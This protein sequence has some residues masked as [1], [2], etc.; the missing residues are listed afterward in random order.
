MPRSITDV[1]DPRETPLEDEI[2][3]PLVEKSEVASKDAEVTNGQDESLVRGPEVNGGPLADQSFS[4]THTKTEPKEIN[5]TPSSVLGTNFLHHSSNKRKDFFG[6]AES[7]GV[8]PPT[9]NLNNHQ[10]NNGSP[11][12]NAMLGIIMTPTSQTQ[13][14]ELPLLPSPQEGGGNPAMSVATELQLSK[15][16]MNPNTIINTPANIFQPQGTQAHTLPNNPI[17]PDAE[18]DDPSIDFSKPSTGDSP[19][20]E[21]SIHSQELPLITSKPGSQE[22]DYGPFTIDEVINLLVYG[23]PTTMTEYADHLFKIGTL[24]YEELL[25]LPQFFALEQ[26]FYKLM[27]LLDY[28][29]TM[30]PDP[31]NSQLHLLV[32][33]NFDIFIKISTNHKKVDFATRTV[34]FLTDIIMRLNYWEIYNLLAWK[35]ALYRFLQLIKF[36]MDECYKRFLTDYSVYTFA[37]VEQAKTIVRPKRRKLAPQKEVEISNGQEQGQSKSRKYSDEVL[38]EGEISSPGTSQNGVGYDYMGEDLS[39]SIS[40]YSE[41]ESSSDTETRKRRRRSDAHSVARPSSGTSKLNYESGVRYF[42]NGQPKRKYSKMAEGESKAAKVIKKISSKP[43]N[44]SSNYDPDVVHECQL[45]S[46]DEPH[47]LCLRRFSR[48][49]ELIRHQETVHS[50]KK[51][52]FKCFVCVKQNPSVGPRIFTRHDTLAKHIRVNHKISGKEAKAEVAFL[53]RHAEVVE[54]GDI[55][56]HVGRRKTKVDFELRKHM[57]KKRLTKRGEGGLDS[58]LEDEDEDLEEEGKDIGDDPFDQVSE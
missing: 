44:K 47:K 11:I 34:R 35:P 6:G 56:V 25:P 4:S 32:Q 52:L 7:T 26:K 8:T 58:S 27:E 1:K 10:F 31:V 39:D 19:I 15:A 20:N 28:F 33:Q 42:G 54:E 46:P 38:S 3:I 9:T 30:Q 21:R 12:K 36:D 48:K 16:P 40:E 41:D 57:E 53:K 37:K 50:K 22:S 5:L 29:C 23:L 49:Y 2:D 14:Q 45:P 43:S 51:K 24:V 18:V 55:T 17:A 13:P